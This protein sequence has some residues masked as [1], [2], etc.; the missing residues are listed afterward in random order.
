MS[1]ASAKIILTEEEGEL[2]T[3]QIIERNYFREKMIQ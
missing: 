1:Q 2:N 3:I